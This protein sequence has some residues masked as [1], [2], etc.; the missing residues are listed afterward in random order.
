MAFLLIWL[1][2]L[3]K[4]IW[5]IYILKCPSCLWELFHSLWHFTRG[6]VLVTPLLALRRRSWNVDRLKTVFWATASYSSQPGLWAWLGITLRKVLWG[7]NFRLSEPTPVLFRPPPRP[8]VVGER[9]RLHVDA[10]PLISLL[11][12]ILTLHFSLFGIQSAKPRLDCLI[13]VYR[14]CQEILAHQKATSTN[15]FR[16][17]VLSS[18]GDDS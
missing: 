5:N 18:K 10:T 12:F 7:L 13:E 4:I 14:S 1:Y 2:P 3:Y 8:R 16:K 11:T 9:S 6:S 17:P 15:P